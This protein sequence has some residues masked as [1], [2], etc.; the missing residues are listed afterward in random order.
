[1]QSK[2]AVLAV[3]FIL[4]VGGIAG[5]AIFRQLQT[6]KDLE[7]QQQKL[8]K[9][10][11]EA[12]RRAEEAKAKAKDTRPAL[13]PS[14]VAARLLEEGKEYERREQ[15]RRARELYEKS[16]AEHE[17]E[18]AKRLLQGV[19]LVTEAEDLF[20]RKAWAQAVKKYEA[21]LDFVYNRAFVLE[22]IEKVNVLL[23]YQ[24]LCRKAEEAA[25]AERFLDAEGI[26]KR[27]Q[28]LAREHKISTDIPLRIY[29]LRQRRE[30][31]KKNADDMRWL[32]QLCRNN[33]RPFAMLAACRY[34][35]NQPLLKSDKKELQTMREA[36]LALAES[37]RRKA[38]HQ[39]GSES[40]TL[41]DELLSVKSPTLLLEKAVSY[42]KE[43]NPF[44]ALECLGILLEEHGD[45]ELVKDP[46]QQKTVIAASSKVK[47][48]YG[49]SIDKMVRSTVGVCAGICDKCLG[50]RYLVCPH[51]GGT[52][53]KTYECE[54]CQ[55]K[56]IITCEACG[57]SGRIEGQ[58]CGECNGKGR[59][60]CPTC[61]GKGVVVLDCNRCNAKTHMV[62]CPRCNGT[63]KR[64]R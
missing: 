17:T 35:S 26:Y 20:G 22:R 64:K 47:R 15:W 3:V 36:A 18:E 12:A 41:D 6:L 53:K 40:K 58:K 23:D 61:K 16:L 56:K 5:R 4:I 54:T 10:R 37:A 24:S 25:A 46:Q 45:S 13:P 55:G 52:G 14:Q 39:A 60:T 7:Q 57:G 27:A 44:A 43:N 30:Q 32:F 38:A 34:Y 19:Q 29:R 1:V 49:D 21:A 31:V 42:C 11:E 9:Q 33:Q 48:T 62:I 63:G 50:A 51:C 2:T 59:I 28:A 8:K